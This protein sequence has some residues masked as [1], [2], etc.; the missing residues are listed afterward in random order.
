MKNAPKIFLILVA[1]AFIAG[2]AVFVHPGLWSL[3]LLLVPGLRPKTPGGNQ[4]PSDLAR[5]A[6]VASDQGLDDLRRGAMESEG[7]GQR[8][9]LR[10]DED[11]QASGRAIDALKKGTRSPSS[12]DPKH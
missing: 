8:L 9:E 1:L 2:L 11:A 3:V 7:A 6:E 5:V 10:L 12:G 4:T